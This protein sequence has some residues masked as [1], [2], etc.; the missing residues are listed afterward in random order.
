M[1]SP[2][3][4]GLESCSPSSKLGSLFLLLVNMSTVSCIL[5][6]GLLSCALG[7]HFPEDE[8]MSALRR[9]QRELGSDEERLSSER[10]ELSKRSAGLNEQT[11]T[12]LPGVEAT[13]HNNSHSVSDLLHFHPPCKHETLSRG[14]WSLSPELFAA[15]N[16][17]RG[18]FSLCV[19]TQ[20]SSA[21]GAA[22]SV[23]NINLSS[24]IMNN[25]I[26]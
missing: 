5:A 8:K 23:H 10:T 1:W 26:T 20:L 14:E 4:W 6:L 25:N 17:P 3:V 13:L 2:E 7:A 21:H 15:V 12:A 22:H 11:C 18:D 24:V 19:V 9:L 16:S